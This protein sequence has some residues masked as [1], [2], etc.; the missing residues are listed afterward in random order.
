MTIMRL[1]YAVLMTPYRC[2]FLYDIVYV[3]LLM[4]WQLM[5]QVELVY[6]VKVIIL[7]YLK[8]NIWGCCWRNICINCNDNVSNIMVMCVCLCVL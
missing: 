1:N 5:L 6:D 4:L 3:L 7:V 2:L 8:K